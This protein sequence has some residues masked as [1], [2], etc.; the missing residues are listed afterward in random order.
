MNFVLNFQVAYLGNLVPKWTSFM[1]N[2]QSSIFPRSGLTWRQNLWRA[3]DKSSCVR[4]FLRVELLS[5]PLTAMAFDST[6][7]WFQNC[8]IGTESTIQLHC[9]T[10]QEGRWRKGSSCWRTAQFHERIRRYRIAECHSPLP[11]W[12]LW[13]PWTA[14]SRSPSFQSVCCFHHS[15]RTLSCRTGMTQTIVPNSWC[16]SPKDPFW[17]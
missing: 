11:W 13:F 10:T 9:V 15:L 8:S 12:C 4:T 16:T 17:S 7:Q 14:Y 2:T 5:S 3:A 1:A 6:F